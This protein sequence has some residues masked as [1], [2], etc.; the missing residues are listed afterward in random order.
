MFVDWFKSKYSEIPLAG[1]DAVLRLTAEGGTIP[2]IARYRKEQTGGLDEVAIEKIIKAKELWDE[3]EKRKAFILGEIESQ[4][5]LTPEL[6]NKIEMS[7][8]LNELE[9]ESILSA[10]SSV[11]NV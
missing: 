9:E 10:E 11:L 3:M 8:E 5:K 2:F 4:N 1:A 6:K 7:Q